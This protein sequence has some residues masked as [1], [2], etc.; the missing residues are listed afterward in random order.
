[1]C[2]LVFPLVAKDSD[3]EMKQLSTVAEGSGHSW[4]FYAGLSFGLVTVVGCSACIIALY[5]VARTT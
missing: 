1:M 2:H 4:I 3:D 5:C